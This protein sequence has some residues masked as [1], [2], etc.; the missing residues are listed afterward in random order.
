[1]YPLKIAID[2]WFTH[3]KN[4]HF[5]PQ[6]RQF[7]NGSTKMSCSVD[8]SRSS[9]LR[10][11]MT[12]WGSEAPHNLPPCPVRCHP[13]ISL[14]KETLKNLVANCFWL[15]DSRIPIWI[16]RI[17]VDIISAKLQPPLTACFCYEQGVGHCSS[18][19]SDLKPWPID[20]D[21]TESMSL[22]DWQWRMSMVFPYS[23]IKKKSHI[24]HL[25]ACFTHPKAEKMALGMTSASPFLCS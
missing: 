25:I 3:W 20:N 12:C 23:S 2:S 18:A 24:D 15:V 13:K 19:R 9:I 11:F 10:H 7:T 6:L 14:S 1:M 17:S 21:R 22:S 4:F 16:M 5:F 8:D